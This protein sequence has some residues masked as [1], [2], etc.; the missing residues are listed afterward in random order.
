[1]DGTMVYEISHE[2]SR[3]ETGTTFERSREE[4]QSRRKQVE[5]MQKRA[6]SQSNVR[7]TD[8]RLKDL[9]PSITQAAERF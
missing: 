8:S 6:R 7:K 3:E 4:V 5:V 9:V 1:M 2:P